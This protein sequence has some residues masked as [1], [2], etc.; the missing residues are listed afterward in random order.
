MLAKDVQER[1]I[2]KT[3]VTITFSAL[4]QIEI[5]NL[6]TVLLTHDGQLLNKRFVRPLLIFYLTI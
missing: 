6:F 5:Q 1:I 4:K 2:N 3:G